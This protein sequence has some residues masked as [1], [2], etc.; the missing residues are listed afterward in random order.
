MKKFPNKKYKYISDFF[1]DYKFDISNSLSLLSLY[2]LTK[3]ARLIEKKYYQIQIFLFVV[4]VVQL[5]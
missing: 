4:M 3:A 5:L 2:N 1:Y